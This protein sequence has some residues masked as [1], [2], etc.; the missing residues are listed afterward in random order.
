M[1][2][3]KEHHEP[4]SGDLR[5]LW[6]SAGIL[7]YWLC[8]LEFN[9]DSCPLDAA[10]RRKSA[11]RKSSGRQAGTPV[12]SG[13]LREGVLYSPSHCWARQINESVLRVGVE[14]GLS[15]AILTPKAVVLPSPGQSLQKKRACA[16]IDTDGGTLPLGAPCNGVVRAINRQL[17]EHPHLL[18][19]QP[20][21]EGW[22][23]D[24]EV[25]ESSFNPA[26][27]L[28][29]NQASSVYAADQDRLMNLLASA[30]HAGRPAVGITLADGGQ[31]L[32]NIAGVLGPAKYFSLLRKVFGA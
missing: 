12:E 20:F 13:G 29:W 11:E 2:S 27:F 5:C 17:S 10:M 1:N 18:L 3:S 16:W 32:Q 9:C 26:D 4:V 14:P 23:F 8:D 22:L 19:M 28:D 30:S 6:M 15:M 21:D 31:R 25:A 24:L 7:S